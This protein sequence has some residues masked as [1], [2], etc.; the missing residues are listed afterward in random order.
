MNFEAYFYGY[1]TLSEEKLEFRSVCLYRALKFHDM[2][3][4]S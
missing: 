4:T 1:A 2:S 3:T